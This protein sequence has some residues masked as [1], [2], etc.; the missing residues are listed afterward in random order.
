MAQSLLT[1]GCKP[2]PHTFFRFGSTV[3]DLKLDRSQR[4]EV[5]NTFPLTE[6]LLMPNHGVTATTRSIQMEITLSV[7][8]IPTEVVCWVIGI[9]VMAAK[10]SRD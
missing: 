4:L 8:N 6:S 9:L 3:T 2:P 7:T 5:P 1:S 10:L